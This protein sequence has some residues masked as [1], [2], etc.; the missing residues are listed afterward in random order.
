MTSDT[1]PEATPPNPT[2]KEV[3]TADVSEGLRRIVSALRKVTEDPEAKEMLVPVLSVV[4]ELPPD[5]RKLLLATFLLASAASAAG[6]SAV[7]RIA[8]V[9]VDVLAQVAWGDE[10]SCT[11]FADLVEE[12]EGEDEE[13]R[14]ATQLAQLRR[15]MEDVRTLVLKAALGFPTPKTTVPAAAPGE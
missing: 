1:P 6:H 13:D 9:P 15:S 10:P 11:T 2:P 5:D 12:Y 8:L 4:E 3:A 7:A 14:D